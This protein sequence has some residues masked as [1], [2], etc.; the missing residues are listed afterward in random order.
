MR[1]LS[2]VQGVA[3]GAGGLG[4]AVR[5]VLSILLLL[6]L[7]PGWSGDTRLPLL[8]RDTQLSATP[9]AVAP[10]QR[11]FGRLTLIGAL[12]LKSEAP[13]FGGFSAIAVGRA[14]VTLLSDGGNWIRF[15]I[16]HGGLV[17]ARAGFL[18]NGPGTGWEKRDRD[19]ESL[20]IDPASGA[21]WVGF[22]GA[23]AIWRYAPGFA[24]AEAR[25]RP[26]GMRG[27]PVNGGA[28]TLVRLRDGRFL[29]IAERGVKRRYPR[30]AL[31]FSGDPT[32][33]VRPWLFG[34]R[35]PNGY[36][37]SDATELP[38]G[39]LLV[40]NRRFSLPF[41]FSAKLTVVP[42]GA[43][44]PGRI[45]QG[46]EIATLG[47]PALGENWEGVAITREDDATIV[48]LVSDK[49]EALLQRT[50]LAKFRLD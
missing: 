37:P 49:D 1:R 15:G 32:T 40:L 29:T 31:V 18:P 21:M 47:A 26:P 50:V 17:D 45:V 34:Y 28:E 20:A 30:P 4:R 16:R 44:R 23:N 38:N 12:V 13:A 27:W 33:G 36:D 6:L 9:I 10:A 14:R 35:P 43:I 8:D 39:D 11:R 22:E 25:V 24:R 5:I 3:R 2:R 42:R 19:S 48:W 46:R 41:R 7:V